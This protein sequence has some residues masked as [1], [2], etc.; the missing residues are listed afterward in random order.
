MTDL[1]TGKKN[2]SKKKPLNLREAQQ[3]AWGLSRFKGDDRGGRGI[4]WTSA[5]RTVGTAGCVC[6]CV[7]H[8]GTEGAPGSSHFIKPPRSLLVLSRLRRP[9][10]SNQRDVNAIQQDHRDPGS[11]EDDGIGRRLQRNIPRGQTQ[12]SH[13]WGEIPMWGWCDFFFSPSLSLSH[14]FFFPKKDKQWHW[15]WRKLSSMDEEELRSYPQESARFFQGLFLTSSADLF[16]VL[17]QTFEQFVS[18]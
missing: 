2:K 5:G 18:P 4:K 7:H 8:R 17:Y 10:S 1:A 13:W 12:M 3:A 14:F 15:Q 11:A 16:G 6:P 9:V